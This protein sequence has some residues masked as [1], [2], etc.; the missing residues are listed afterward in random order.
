MGLRTMRQYIYHTDQGSSKTDNNSSRDNNIINSINITTT[1]ES[2]LN[3]LQHKNGL[4]PENNTKSGFAIDKNSEVVLIA[5]IIEFMAAYA[6]ILKSHFR[7]LLLQV[8]YIICFSCIHCVYYVYMFYFDTCA[9][10]SFFHVYL[11]YS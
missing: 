8:C 9:F 1:L 6:F 7:G 4:K 10:V 2:T 5:V 11:L 3:I